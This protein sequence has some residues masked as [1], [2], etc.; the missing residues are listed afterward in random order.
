MVMT[1]EPVRDGSRLSWSMM[2]DNGC[3]MREA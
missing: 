1:M 2:R 3:A